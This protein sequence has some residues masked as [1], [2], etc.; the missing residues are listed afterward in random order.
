MGNK[1]KQFLLKNYLEFFGTKYSHN[2]NLYEICKK[3]HFMKVIYTYANN[4]NQA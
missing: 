1:N 2:K 3:D 4:K